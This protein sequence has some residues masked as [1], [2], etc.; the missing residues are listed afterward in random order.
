MYKTLAWFGH[1]ADVA[2]QWGSAPAR[3]TRTIGPRWGRGRSL[4]RN[5]CAD[6][7]G[8]GRPSG[9]CSRAATCTGSSPD[10]MRGDRADNGQGT[11]FGCRARPDAGYR[12]S[13]GHDQ[14]V[15]CPCPRRRGRRRIHSP[16]RRFSAGHGRHVLASGQ[17]HSLS[18]R[19]LHPV[20]RLP[21]A[22]PPDSNNAAHIA[23]S[24]PTASMASMRIKNIAV[25]LKARGRFRDLTLPWAIP[26]P[27]AE[28]RQNYPAGTG[29]TF[30][31]PPSS[32]IAT[33][34]IVQ[35][36]L[37]RTTESRTCA[38]QMPHIGQ[39]IKHPLTPR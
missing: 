4:V 9:S 16:G 34:S 30:N 2:P 25:K 38:V 35:T 1:G 28:L 5:G 24:G 11:A 6:M 7:R 15:H 23:R 32:S 13:R 29:H 22:V 8:H 39:R 37:P 19:P 33:Q 12:E 14:P 3:R 31:G 21:R 18:F 17:Q 27:A 20:H 36:E 26:T 10:R